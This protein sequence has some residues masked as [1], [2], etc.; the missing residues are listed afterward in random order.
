MAEAYFAALS[1]LLCAD[2]EIG[3]YGAADCILVLNADMS[4]IT[5]CRFASTCVTLRTDK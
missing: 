5:D 2:H 3:V 1:L 4:G